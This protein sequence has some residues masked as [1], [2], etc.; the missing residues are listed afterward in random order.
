MLGFAAISQTA[1]ATLPD[2][3]IPPPPPVGDTHDGF[4]R[5][6]RR[7]RAIE[8]A[9]RK[10]EEERLTERNALRLSLEAAMG[11][12]AEVVED[13]PQ[14]A[15]E[16][17]EAAVAEAAVFV[18]A[19]GRVAP[20]LPLEATARALDKLQAAIE[21]ALRAKALADDDEDVELLLRA[22]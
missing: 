17:V 2:A 22:L 8:A 12:A 4:L 20:A 3:L 19:L 10:A 7:E 13:A 11:M 21:S 6:S 14:E 1:I 15:A 5:R 16:A 18:P 9:R